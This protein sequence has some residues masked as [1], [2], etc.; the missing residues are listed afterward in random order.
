MGCHGSL[1]RAVAWGVLDSRPG[2]LECR[3]TF[4]LE[5]G[6]LPLHCIDNV[7]AH[8]I[9]HVVIPNHFPAFWRM[10]RRMMPDWRRRRA[11]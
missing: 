4:R 9:V 6:T 8:E 1:A 11:G 2:E 7:V 3:I 10:R 5:P